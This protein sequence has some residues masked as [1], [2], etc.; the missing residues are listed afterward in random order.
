METLM[1]EP[2]SL[3]VHTAMAAAGYTNVT[4]A[5]GHVDKTGAQL[6]PECAKKKVAGGPIGE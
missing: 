5:C 4:N 2:M 3:V 6:C 1:N